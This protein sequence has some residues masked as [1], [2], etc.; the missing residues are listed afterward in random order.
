VS[1]WRSNLPVTV[2]DVPRAP[3]APPDEPDGAC[4]AY[5]CPRTGTEAHGAI[6]CAFHRGDDVVRAGTRT[7]GHRAGDT[8]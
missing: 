6:L 3:Q 4:Q 2:W 5:G 1:G 7:I 8:T